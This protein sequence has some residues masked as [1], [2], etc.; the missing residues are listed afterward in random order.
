MVVALVARGF[1]QDA[2]PVEAGAGAARTTALC[3][4]MPPVNT[5]GVA[6]AE[7]GEVGADVLLDA[8]GEHV[9]RQPAASSPASARAMT[10][11]MSD[12]P[13]RPCRPLARLRSSSTPRCGAAG[14]RGDVGDDRGVDVA[15]PGAHDQPLERRQAHRGVDA[16]T[17]GDGGHRR[18][19]AEVGDDQVELGERPAEELGGAAR[20]R[21]RATCRGTRSGA[22]RGARTTRPARRSGRRPR[23][24]CGGTR[25]RT[26]RPEARRATAAR[27]TSMPA[28][29]AG[30]CSGASGTSARNV[31]S[32]SSSTTVGAVNASPPWTTRCPTA[33]TASRRARRR[34]R[35]APA[36]WS[37]T[38]STIPPP[39]ALTGRR[40]DDWYL[41]DE[42][43]VLSTSTRISRPPRPGWP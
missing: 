24:A 36:S 13:H 37:A 10:S 8:V 6:A 43:P 30:L 11:R 18:P 35:P 32:T 5:S 20:R 27:A 15:R 26:R 34:R 2:E 12:A 25:C 9:Q 17:A 40:V 22:R 14:R 4:P 16:A 33:S 39:R 1:E 31:G 21:T 7:H 29:L 3:S 19:V 41:I 28:R 38:S 23:A 42:L